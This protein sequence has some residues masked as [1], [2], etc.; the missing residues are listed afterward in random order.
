[1]QI[2][3]DRIT[4]EKLGAE[5]TRNRRSSLRSTSAYDS[6]YTALM[7]SHIGAAINEALRLYSV[8]PFLVKTV[9]ATQVAP[10]GYELQAEG[11]SYILPPKAAVFINTTAMHCHPKLWPDNPQ[12]N[13]HRMCTCDELAY[14]HKDQPRHRTNPVDCFNPS[15]WFSNPTAFIY[16]GPAEREPLLKPRPGS[17]IPFSDGHR[18]CLGKQFGLVELC[19]VTTRILSEYS[20]ELVVDEGEQGSKQSV[21][22]DYSEIWRAAREKARRALMKDVKFDMSLRMVGKIPLRFVERGAEQGRSR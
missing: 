12:K 5:E 6:C 3:I 2:D 10:G 9:P 16:D 21:R 17:F 1:M 11:Q 15:R 19:A 14:K 4:A 18:G 8:I 7:K 13:A 22:E 20:V